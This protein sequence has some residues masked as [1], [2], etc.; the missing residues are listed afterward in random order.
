MTAGT[1]NLQERNRIQQIRVEACLKVKMKKNED[2]DAADQEE[3]HW[4]RIWSWHSGR[5]VLTMEPVL[6]AGTRTRGAD[7]DQEPRA[8]RLASIPAIC[9][10]QIESRYE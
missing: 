1:L 9:P 7:A 5:G 6:R 4:R 10:W 2:E 3:C 8:P